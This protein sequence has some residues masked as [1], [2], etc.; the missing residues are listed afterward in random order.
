MLK[1]T[2]QDK[3]V[4]ARSRSFI[5]VLVNVD[6]QKAIASKYAIMSIP[7][8]IFMDAKGGVILRADQGYQNAAD[9]LKTM[10][11]AEKRSKS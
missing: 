3:A 6:K 2:Y 8:V 7:T 10:D 11:A 4:V 9:F 1:T 5:P